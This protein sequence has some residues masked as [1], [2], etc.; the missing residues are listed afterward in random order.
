[1]KKELEVQTIICHNEN[2][3]TEYRLEQNKKY[4]NARELKEL[5][6]KKE[7]I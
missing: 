2:I 3:L 6:I 5:L 7:T 4:K 1:M